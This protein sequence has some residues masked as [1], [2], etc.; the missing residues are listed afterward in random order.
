MGD[1][2]ETIPVNVIADVDTDIAPFVIALQELADKGL[3]T[4]ASCQGVE[5]R[6]PPQ[7]MCTWPK[8]LDAELRR[9]YLVSDIGE[10]FGY[11][12]PLGTTIPDGYR[13]RIKDKS[14]QEPTP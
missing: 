12:H 8:E 11:L 3:R 1:W 9:R 13:E 2:H 14:T 10:S 5:G 6:Y 7:V 4:H